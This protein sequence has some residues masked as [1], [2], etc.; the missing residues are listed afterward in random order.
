MGEGLELQAPRAQETWCPPSRS[1]E[2]QSQGCSQPQQQQESQC[3][4]QSWETAY[5]G[6]PIQESTSHPPQKP[7]QRQGQGQRQV[8]DQRERSEELQDSQE[9]Q[10]D[11]TGGRKRGEIQ[12]DDGI[13]LQILQELNF[14]YGSDSVDIVFNMSRFFN[15]LYNNTSVKDLYSQLDIAIDQIAQETEAD[16]NNV[17][18]DISKLL[19]DN[20]VDT[21]KIYLKNTNMENSKNTS[22]NSVNKP[23]LSYLGKRVVNLSSCKLS[24]AHISVLEKGITF[25]PTPKGADLAEIHQDV[26]DFFRR[27]R[28]K[29]HFYD[30][31]NPSQES[32]ISDIPPG[33]VKFKKKSTWC[34]KPNDHSLN[35]FIE[36]VSNDLSTFDPDISASKN[37]SFEENNAL[38]DLKGNPDIVIK[39]ADKSSS[40]VVMNKGDYVKEAKRQLSDEKFYRETMS[41]YTKEFNDHINQLLENLKSNEAISEELHKC[42]VTN[43][44]KTASLYLLPKTHKVKKENEFPPGRPI[45]SANGCP[46]E[47]ISAFV[48]ENI[49]GFIPQIASY[50]KDTTD[51]IRKI[52]NILVPEDC[53]LVTFDV[54]S[55]YTNIPNDEG[56][57][58]VHNFLKRHK[59]KYASAD[60]IILL[61]SE[62]LTKNNFEFDGK[63]YLQI[64]GTAMGTRL[65]PSY[66]NIFMGELETK[67]IQS[68]DKEPLLWVRFIDD[69]FSI[70]THGEAELHKYH[71]H[72]NSYHENIKYTMEHSYEKITF[73]DTWVKKLKDKLIVELYTKPTDTHNYLHFTSSHP[74][75]MKRA[76]PYGQFLRVRRNC[77][78]NSDYIKH[79]LKIKKHYIERGYPEQLVE[80]SRLQALNKDRKE[81]LKPKIHVN[82][83]KPNIVPLVLTH[84]PSNFLVRK[85]INDNWGM[86]KYSELCQKA[87]PDTPLYAT[88]RSKNIKDLLVRSRLKPLETGKNTIKFVPDSCHRPFCRLCKSLKQDNSTCTVTNKIHNIPRNIDCHTKNVVYV[89]TCS[90]CKKQYVGETKRN[91]FLRYKEHVAGIKHNRNYPIT[92]HCKEHPN[93]NL[94]TILSPRIL[95]VIS[96]NPDLRETDDH[97]KK[98]ELHWIY[99]FRSL[100]PK[101][102]NVMGQ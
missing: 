5:Q 60:T 13:I 20:I 59:P 15:S 53:I 82:E 29:V 34:P 1:T 84:H 48:D 45:I 68:Y 85:I 43:N 6:Q 47:K 87:L 56:I 98:R 75:H 26:S 80:N 91:F 57:N 23:K 40:I 7:T 52:E 64:G 21:N 19:L 74:K 27:L 10:T 83:S 73:L 90:I 2:T 96:R 30:E 94:D 17:N 71:D 55:L 101:G 41:D 33:L 16:L 4:E 9:I 11:T 49:K 46:T 22:V 32:F 50:I 25:C 86:L 8:V 99:K 76:G 3:W 42:L 28:L 38:K 95:E 77:T 36:K 79:S 100:T 72:L 88:R 89:L 102:L 97:R 51:F 44:P 39:K 18:I 81:L 69:I 14:L 58:A 66:A 37:L 67:T 92:Q 62:V 61:L 54:T 31:E 65:A 78:L 12:R 24:K 35:G 70:W 93:L 63:N